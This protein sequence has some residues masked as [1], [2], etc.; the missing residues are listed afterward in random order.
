MALFD[1]CN[2]AEVVGKQSLMSQQT[3]G[4]FAPSSSGGPNLNNGFGG[5]KSRLT[6]PWDLVLGF[7]GCLLIQPAATSHADQTR[8]AAFPF[9][10]EAAKGAGG[11]TT[12]E[13]DVPA[14]LWMPLWSGQALAVEVQRL[15]SEGRARVG[16][17]AA[18]NSV[19]L[20]RAVVT[21]GIDRGV[22]AFQ[23]YA[24]P[25][26]NGKNHLAVPAG[27]FHVRDGQ[28]EERLL[29]ELDPWLE[30]WHRATRDAKTT[31]ARFQLHRRLLDR[32]VI[33]VA[34]FGGKQRM[35][36]LLEEVGA[37]Q[38][39]LCT[40]PKFRVSEGFSV[41]SPLQGL[42]PAWVQELHDGSHEFELA[43]SIAG[44]GAGG[45]GLPVRMNLEPVEGRGRTWKWIS[46]SHSGLGLGLSNDLSDLM[47]E[48]AVQVGRSSKEAGADPR[49]SLVLSSRHNLSA[50]TV[51]AFLDGRL[52][53]ERTG[54]LV[55][56]LLGVTELPTRL[57]RPSEVDHAKA[58]S[59][60]R[61]YALLKL[62]L[63]PEWASPRALMADNDPPSRRLEVGVL[64]RLRAGHLGAA[65]EIVR[66]R[67]RSESLRPLDGTVSYPDP[68]RLAAAL[69]LPI[70]KSLARDLC[71]LVLPAFDTE[72]QEA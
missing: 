72:S 25:Q 6:N 44:L 24:F 58:E 16:R 51:L 11:A 7:E 45:T 54:R 71:R 55:H 17:R 47:L 39:A 5:E 14:E 68:R 37:A 19:D 34:Q 13:E 41:V 12:E 31:P 63:L 53:E 49:S 10:V 22:T 64:H 70:T 38:R 69:T 35:V 1:S 26:R 33:N 32:A 36:G 56:A 43:W 52:D 50:S 20:A 18:R 62:G 48:R 23:R 59:L 28:G 21:H 4:Q 29:R 65:S 42:S 67:L 15:F 2:G 9:Q 8:G 60:P 57:D 66:R 27:T 40:A 3:L 61:A 30:S 46:E